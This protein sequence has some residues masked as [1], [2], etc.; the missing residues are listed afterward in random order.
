MLFLMRIV[1]LV[2]QINFVLILALLHT[3]LPYRV[4]C[5]SDCTPL[6]HPTDVILVPPPQLEI[7]LTGSVYHAAAAKQSQ[8]THIPL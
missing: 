5:I 3:A 1:V 2:Y 8:I 6:S 4:I 7:V